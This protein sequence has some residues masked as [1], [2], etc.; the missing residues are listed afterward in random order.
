MVADS[1]GTARP[2]GAPPEAGSPARADGETGLRAG[3][4]AVPVGEVFLGVFLLLHLLWGADPGRRL[5][6][7]RRRG[8]LL[9]R[10]TSS[11]QFGRTRLAPCALTV[12]ATILR[13]HRNVKTRG[14]LD[15]A[16]AQTISAATSLKREPP[17]LRLTRD[18]PRLAVQ[19]PI[20]CPCLSSTTAL[21]TANPRD[22]CSRAG[23]DNIPHDWKETL[24]PHEVQAHSERVTR[25]RPPTL[26]C[27]L[28][29]W[30]KYAR[31]AG[32]GSAALRPAKKTR[33]L[34]RGRSDSNTTRVTLL[35]LIRLRQMRRLVRLR[36][37]AGVP[38]QHHRV[39]ASLRRRGG[40]PRVS[41]GL[42]LA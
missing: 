35:L 2:T 42:A 20:P 29:L 14:A 10:R 25:N 26:F 32:A 9:D 7:V 33:P 3:D 36:A 30:P 18:S 22:T 5:D 21:R 41:R 15:C 31:E 8:R 40:L 13:R 38:R 24:L 34:T 23:P 11:G 39:S 4:V 12:T 27:R 28:P 1:C 19:K 37:E 17:A 16:Q 6:W